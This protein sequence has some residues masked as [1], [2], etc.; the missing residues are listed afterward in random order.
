M[1]KWGYCNGDTTCECGLATENTSH[2]MQCTTP[3]TPMHLGRPSTAQACTERWKKIGL[4][5]RHD[6]DINI[7]NI[8]AQEKRVHAAQDRYT[9]PTTDK[10]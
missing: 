5:I 2:M 9:C 1:K 3:R 6:D 4:I 10:T 8:R 7:P